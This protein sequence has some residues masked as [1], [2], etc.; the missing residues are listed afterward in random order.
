MQ[1]NYVEANHKLRTFIQ[2]AKEIMNS[3]PNNKEKLN[4]YLNTQPEDLTDIIVEA[5]E[6]FKYEEN[7]II[8]FKYDKFYSF[9][10]EKQK[11]VRY[12]IEATLLNKYVGEFIENEF[13]SA[14]LTQT[15]KT[16]EE[17]LENTKKILD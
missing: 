10:I 14:D 13:G 16:Y 3:E 7:N 11:F 8:N 4:E 17:V 15:F 2:G 1:P 12:A 9:D 6:L 5:M